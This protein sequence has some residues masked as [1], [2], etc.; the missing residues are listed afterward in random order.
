[1]VREIDSEKRVQLC[2]TCICLCEH[3]REDWKG[4]VTRLWLLLYAIHIM[5]QSSCFSVLSTTHHR[6]TA[7]CPL[8]N[9]DASTPPP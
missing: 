2:S 5:S 8:A 9:P 7:P 1:M 3:S 4:T 6:R